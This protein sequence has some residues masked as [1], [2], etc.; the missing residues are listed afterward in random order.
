MLLDDDTLN[1]ACAGHDP[2]LYRLVRSHAE[3]LLAQE[4][5]SDAT[6]RGQ[7]RRVVVG[8]VAQG[9]PEVAAV[10]RALAVFEKQVLADARAGGGQ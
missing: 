3:L 5:R 1:A 4:P 2:N 10:A 9:E 6:M 8:M 7:A